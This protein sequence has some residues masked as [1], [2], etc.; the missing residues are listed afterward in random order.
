LFQS[1]GWVDVR[2]FSYRPAV[3]IGTIRALLGTGRVWRDGF[4]GQN[5]IVGIVDEGINGIIYPVIGGLSQSATMPPG[6]APVASHG[7]MC[8]AAVLIAAPGAQLYDYPFLGIPDSGGAMTMYHEILAQRR[9]DGTPHLTNN[10]FGVVGEIPLDPNH[11][12]NDI[13]H[14]LHRK[15][16]ELVASGAPVFFA[17]GNC[18][19]DSPSSVCGLT[20]I[21]PGRS[22]HGP[23][24]L[25]E[26]I[27]IAAVNSRH[28][29]IGY[30]SQGPGMFDPSKPDL[31]AY[32]HFL[33]NFGPGRPG[34]IA[35]QIF[36][37]GTSAASPLAAG[38]GAL[39]M[40]AI[41]GLTPTRLKEA[42]IAAAIPMGVPGWNGDTGHGIINAA[43]TYAFL[44][45]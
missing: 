43:A 40:S 39:L 25:N 33:A 28:E 24:S 41:P 27:T 22:I 16:R 20:G 21:G 14:P 26:V 18:G 19:A 15:I 38:V 8:A 11:E 31:A 42:L 36:D 6:A 17:A 13:N 34:G 3:P 10:S 32:S 44:R 37:N 5:I 4:Y 29:R 30:S 35:K 1:G 45:R 12:V 9:K 2:P 7:S 23:N